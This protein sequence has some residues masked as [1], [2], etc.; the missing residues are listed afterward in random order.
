MYW[1]I[2]IRLL[3]VNQCTV[4]GDIQT[5][6]L[7]GREVSPFVWIFLY[8]E[9]NDGLILSSTIRTTPL[10]LIGMYMLNISNRENVQICRPLSRKYIETHGHLVSCATWTNAIRAPDI[11]CV[12]VPGCL[13]LCIHLLSLALNRQ[14]RPDVS[15]PCANL[16]NTLTDIS[17]MRRKSTVTHQIRW[18]D[19]YKKLDMALFM[20]LAMQ[21]ALKSPISIVTSSTSYM[22]SFLP[23]ESKELHGL[24]IDGFRTWIA[25]N[26]IEQSIEVVELLVRRTSNPSEIDRQIQ[27]DIECEIRIVRSIVE[28]IERLKRFQTSCWFMSQWRT[29]SLDGTANDLVMS[30][31]LI[32]SKL[33]LL[34]VL[35]ERLH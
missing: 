3:A 4:Y 6:G 21:K 14:N 31:K 34:G 33:N 16:L 11:E 26:N 12:H 28:Q 15:K 10:S 8:S 25:H 23:R 24:T 35:R 20:H 1:H 29:G 22:F 19:K 2:P 9:G 27:S 30:L 17:I 7:I 32:Q 18:M 5:R 13:V